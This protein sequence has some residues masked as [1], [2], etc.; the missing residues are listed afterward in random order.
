VQRVHFVLV[1]RDQVV[2]FNLDAVA[3]V[4]QEG[5]PLTLRQPLDLFCHAVNL[6]IIFLLDELISDL[7]KVEDLARLF[8]LE[9]LRFFE[10]LAR[11]NHLLRVLLSEHFHFHDGLSLVNNENLVPPCREF[12]QLNLVLVLDLELFSVMLVVEGRFEA[13]ARLLTY[14]YDLF[15]ALLSLMPVAI[16]FV[17]LAHLVEGVQV[18]L[19]TV[20]IEW[21]LLWCLLLVLVLVHW[22]LGG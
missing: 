12:L 13:V 19:N 7:F 20:Y 3:A 18:R 6:R 15:E 17:H 1:L 4:R 2:D 11:L 10:I 16:A 21:D 14:L 22:V 9:S 8:V 5:A